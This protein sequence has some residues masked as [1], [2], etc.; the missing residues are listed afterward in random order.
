MAERV[1]LIADDDVHFRTALRAR[2]TANGYDVVECFDGV[3]AIAA[4]RF[5]R[6]DAIILDHQMPAGE[7]RDVAR[8]IRAESD[9]PIIFISGRAR[10]E[11]RRV[12]MELPE[13][14]YLP[15]PLDAGKLLDLLRALLPEPNPAQPANA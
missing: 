9:V 11:F 5:S 12:V 4:Q 3:G 15:K 8:A 13:T 2:L 1:I 7:G 14:Y 10:D 6:V